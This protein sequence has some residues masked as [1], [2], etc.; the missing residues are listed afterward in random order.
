MSE[1][2][3]SDTK[4]RE[5]LAADLAAINIAVHQPTDPPLFTREPAPTMVACHWK[6]AD[7]AASLE[8]IGAKSQA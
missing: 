1:V 4:A 6:A 3:G 5:A 8:R 7:I 2:I